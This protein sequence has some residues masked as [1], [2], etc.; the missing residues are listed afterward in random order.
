[1]SD[2]QS[3]HCGT[4]RI[5]VLDLALELQRLA[6]EV[7]KSA[8]HQQEL[9]CLSNLTALGSLTRLMSETLSEDISVSSFD[10]E[11]IGE[12][13]NPIGFCGPSNVVSC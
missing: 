12:R 9:V 4:R 7:M 3:P 8:R 10:D 13:K 2:S 1:M 5:T 11:R 6:A